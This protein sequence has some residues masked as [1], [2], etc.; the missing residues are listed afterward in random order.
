V[1]ETLGRNAREK[2]RKARMGESEEERKFKHLEIKYL[3]VPKN[4]LIEGKKRS[5]GEK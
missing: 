2:K 4:H 1:S 5:N 3:E